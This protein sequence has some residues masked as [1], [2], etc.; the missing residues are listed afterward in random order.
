[1]RISD[2]SPDV[3]SSA[4]LSRRHAAARGGTCRGVKPRLP[5]GPCGLARARFQRLRLRDRPSAR[6]LRSHRY[7]R[8][9]PDGLPQRG[10]AARQTR[11]ADPVRQCRPP[12]LPRDA[13]ELPPAAALDLRPHRLPALSRPDTAAVARSEEHTSEL[14]SLLRISYAVFRLKKNKTEHL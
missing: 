2:W 1:M 5:V 3:C 9:V 10:A 4:L 6:P 7:R 13:G 12:P 11:R 8:T 14:Q